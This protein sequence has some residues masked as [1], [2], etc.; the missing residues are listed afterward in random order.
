MK[1]ETK[2]HPEIKSLEKRTV[3]AQYIESGCF[4]GG[5]NETFDAEI[6]YDEKCRV[7]SEKTF[8]RLVELASIGAR[9]QV[10]AAKPDEAVMHEVRNALKS[11][12]S[13]TL[14]LRVGTGDPGITHTLERENMMS[15]AHNSLEL[16]TES[17]AGR[18]HL[19]VVA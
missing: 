10:S 8:S 11:I 15:F 1:T 13:G 12:A 19:E 16:L 18:K 14:T 6:K 4:Q 9:S 5:E 3:K 7:M 17:E 2:Q